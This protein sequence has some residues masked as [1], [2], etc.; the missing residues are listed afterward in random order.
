MLRI[1]LV[2]GCAFNIL[3]VIKCMHYSKNSELKIALLLV[4]IIVNTEC[5]HSQNSAVGLYMCLVSCRCFKRVFQ[6]DLF[7]CIFIY[8]F[9]DSYTKLGNM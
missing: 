9:T 1:N 7:K 4:N 2:I 6:V 5:Q 3:D 8:A